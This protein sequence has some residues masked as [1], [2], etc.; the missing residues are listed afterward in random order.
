MKNALVI[1][2]SQS[3]KSP[4]I[5]SVMQ[6]ARKDGAITV[7]I[8]NQINSP[9]AKTAEYVIPML[10]GKEEAVAATKSYIASLSTLVQLTAHWSQNKQ[11][12]QRINDPRVRDL[13]SPY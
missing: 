10:A 2:I 7:A 5:C 1:G 6:A 8:V 9:L 12:L 13:H 11:L 4:D 3:G